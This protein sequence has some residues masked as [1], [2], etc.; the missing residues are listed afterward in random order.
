MSLVRRRPPPVEHL[1]RVVFSSVVMVHSS[2]FSLFSRLPGWLCW[3]SA[4]RSRLSGWLCWLSACRSRLSGWLC[5][6]SAC[7][8]PP[9][10]LAALAVRL[11]GRLLRLPC[12][13]CVRWSWLLRARNWCTGLFLFSFSC[14]FSLSLPLSLSLSLIAASLGPWFP[15]YVALIELHGHRRAK[16]HLDNL[17][18]LTC[19]PNAKSVHIRHG[20]LTNNIGSEEQCI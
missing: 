6:L 8:V 4:C 2:L 16:D 15:G 18:Q 7:W 17:G 14:L 19:D 5:W 12:P 11:S 3:L 1:V 13:A 20:Q 10:G 9:A